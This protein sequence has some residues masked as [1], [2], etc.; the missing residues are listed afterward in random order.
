MKIDEMK[1]V[2]LRAVDTRYVDYV[3]NNWSSF[4]VSNVDKRTFPISQ[5]AVSSVICGLMKAMSW[6]LL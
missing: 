5:G 3:Q 2:D 4:E 1:K 6:I